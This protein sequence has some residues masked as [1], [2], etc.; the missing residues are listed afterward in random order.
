MLDQ[1]REELAEHQRK[2]TAIRVEAKAKKQA[3][4]GA[5]PPPPPQPQQPQQPPKD[6]V[7][8]ESRLPEAAVVEI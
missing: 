7:I 2:K 5:L 4:K 1:H 3:K 8:D 6:G